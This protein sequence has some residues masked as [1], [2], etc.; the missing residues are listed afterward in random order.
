MVKGP[1]NQDLAVCL[2]V[3]LG[4]AVNDKRLS[5]VSGSPACLRSLLKVHKAVLTE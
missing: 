4:L 2:L 5:V 3:D 1:G